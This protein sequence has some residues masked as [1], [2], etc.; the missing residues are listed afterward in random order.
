MNRNTHFF[1]S[2][3]SSNWRYFYGY[4]ILLLIFLK[5]IGVFGCEWNRDLKFDVQIIGLQIHLSIWLELIYRIYYNKN[6][7]TNKNRIGL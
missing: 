3:E 6:D 7:F 2:S 1:R 4:L 5:N